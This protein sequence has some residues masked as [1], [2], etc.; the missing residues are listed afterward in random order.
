MPRF[1]SAFRC[2][3]NPIFLQLYLAQTVNLIGDALSWVGIALLSFE[4]AGQGSGALLAGLLTV[5]VTAFVVLSPI[6]GVIADHCDRKK[7]MITTHLARMVI[8]SLFP[9]A[10][11]IW[12]IYLIVLLLNIFYAFF[13]PTYTATIPLVTTAGERPK[14]IA[15][16][17]ATYQLLSVIGPALAGSVAAFIGL[18]SVFFLDGLTFLIAAILIAVLPKQLM[19]GEHQSVVHQGPSFLQSILTGTQCVWLD[20]FIRYALILQFITALAGASILVNTVGYVQGIL[21]LGKAEYGWV[22]AAF[23][24]GATITSLILGSLQHRISLTNLITCGAVLISLA[25]LP[26]NQSG[27]NTLLLLWAIAGM[28]QTLVNVPT[29]TLIA[30][31]VTVEVQGRVYG[32]HFAWS[33]L[34]WAFAYPIAGLSSSLVP[35]STFFYTSII[36][37]LLFILAY[38]LLS[39]HRREQDIKGLWH[40]HMHT[41]ENDHEHYHRHGQT[42]VHSHIHFHT[43]D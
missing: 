38:S 5:R 8:I 11:Q 28:G 12:Q 43:V 6:A 18:R 17:S 9:F 37:L 15:L 31:R 1:P 22:M 33:H 14:A 39:R 40:E 29:Q 16:S 3:Q 27:L 2:L 26:A 24:I 25:L 41:H 42:L 20:L 4:L 32:A 21:N 23:G 35:Q 30:E 10:T 13:T 36:C 7:I 34:W 19:V